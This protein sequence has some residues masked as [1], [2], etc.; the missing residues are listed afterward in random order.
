LSL[1]LSL[2]LETDYPTWSSNEERALSPVDDYNIPTMGSQWVPTWD[3]YNV[4]T[5]GSQWHPTWDDYN[6]P[7]RHDDLNIPTMVFSLSLSLETDYPTSSWSSNEEPALSPVDDYYIPTM[8]S[9]FPSPLFIIIIVICLSLIVVGCCRLSGAVG[10]SS[11]GGTGSST[12]G[13]GGDGGGGGCGG[14]CGGGG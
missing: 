4:P 6:N 5:M 10:D 1:S 7:T 9:Q 2:S 14:G 11:A 12:F 8:G 13:F 3:D